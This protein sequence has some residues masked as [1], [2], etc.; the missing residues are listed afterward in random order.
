[1]RQATPPVLG[2]ATLLLLGAWV[3][4]ACLRSAGGLV[5][6]LDDTYIHMSIA[7]NVAEPRAPG[8]SCRASSPRRRR[9]CCGRSCWRSPSSCS[10]PTRPCPCSST[11]E[12]LAGLLWTANRLLD[13]L[14]VAPRS[15]ALVALV[16]LVPLPTLVWIGM[17]HTLHA[18]V[19]LALLG[20]AA[21]TE[22]RRL[23][24]LVALA[25]ISAPAPL[26]GI[27]RRVQRGCPARGAGATGGR[28][29]PCARPVRCPSRPSAS[30]HS[31]AAGTC[32]QRG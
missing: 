1:M 5:Y 12:R 29:G 3:G 22:P 28:P 23:G 19:T 2:L 31:R 21:S 10:G 11:R 16:V 30:I 14:D 26:R 8:G 7:R 6:A 13:D 4:S 20:R 25:A 9:R 17:E 15:A 32:F 18:W 27:V 24:E